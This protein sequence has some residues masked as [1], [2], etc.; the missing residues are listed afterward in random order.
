MKKNDEQG[1]LGDYRACIPREKG[2]PKVEV[3]RKVMIAFPS[4]PMQLSP[5]AIAGE[6]SHYRC[7]RIATRPRHHPASTAHPA[8]SYPDQLY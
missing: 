6:G 8:D 5:F 7:G 2:E 3:G 1:M 4:F